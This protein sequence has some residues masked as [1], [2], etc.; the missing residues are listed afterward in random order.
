MIKLTRLNGQQ[1]YINALYIEEVQSFPDT[2]L[3]LTSGKKI[4][5]REREDDVILLV[6][7]FYRD[8]TI[9]GHIQKGEEE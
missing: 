2:T 9:L 7:E 5:V 8:I 6:K 1:F 4:V 3:T